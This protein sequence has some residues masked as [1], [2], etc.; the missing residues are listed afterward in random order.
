MRQ[1]SLSSKQGFTLIEVMIA[2]L[3]LAMGMMAVITMEY[4]A[5]RAYGAS[6]DMTVATDLADRTVALM[7]VEGSN[8]GARSIFDI[9]TPSSAL[10]VYDITTAP[11]P[12][13]L[14]GQII[15]P[16]WTWQVA[17]PTP[18]TERLVPDAQVGRYCVYVRGGFSSLA[19]GG[20]TLTQPDG[21]DMTVTPLVQAQV[22]VIY[23]TKSTG[24]AMDTC[25]SIRCRGGTTEATSLL[26]PQGLDLT[27]GA[28]ED[29]VPELEQC[30]WRAVY[31]GAL[32]SR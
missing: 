14:V 1:A 16:E 10:P 23:P 2:T 5:L 32:I 21:T 25:L 9:G 27:A 22:A 15:S 3:V 26:N 13:N 8:W 12:Q 31:T 28:F 6:R 17:T 19:L 20:G 11:M 29:A 4:S 7:R 24:Y 30:G 18:V